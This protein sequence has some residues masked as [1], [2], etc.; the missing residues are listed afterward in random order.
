MSN[1]KVVVQGGVGFPGLL[2][3]VLLVCKLFGA[4]ITWFWVF[5]P[6]WIP[7]ALVTGSFLVSI[8]IAIFVAWK[9]KLL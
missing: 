7:L 4:N 2:F 8:L 5:A 9:R 3:I 6:L 1:N